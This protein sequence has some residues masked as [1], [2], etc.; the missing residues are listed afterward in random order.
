MRNSLLVLFTFATILSAKEDK[1][2][3]ALR[4]LDN[5]KREV[6]IGRAHV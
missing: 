5:L 2:A 6:E 1:A 4:E 3:A